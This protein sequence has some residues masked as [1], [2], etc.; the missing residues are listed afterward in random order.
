MRISISKGR[1]SET[2]FS[3]CTFFIADVNSESTIRTNIEYFWKQY[4][5]DLDPIVE[6]LVILAMG[7]FSVDKRIPRSGLINDYQGDNWTRQIELQIPVLELNKWEG[8]KL[9]LSKCI[10]FL[11]GDE[12]NINFYQ[13]DIRFRPSKKRDIKKAKALPEYDSVSLFSGGLDSF[14]GAIYYLDKG[15]R[16]LFIGC[17]EYVALEARIDEVFSAIA[18]EF[19]YENDKVNVFYVNPKIPQGIDQEVRNRFRENTSRTRSFLFLTAAIVMAS[20]RGGE[21]P[22][23]V[24]ENGFIGINVPLTP[25]RLGSC[26]TRTT[27]VKFLSDFNKILEKVGIHNQ[28][29]NP[30][31]CMSKGQI[32]ALIREHPSF[33]LTVGKTISCSHPMQ[34]RMQKAPVP[35]NCGYCYPCIIRKASLFCNGIIDEYVDSYNHNLS[36]SSDFLMNPKYSN[37]D[38]GMNR[39]FRAVLYSLKTFEL[40]D[41]TKLKGRLIALCGLQGQEVDDFANMY[42]KSM[43]E[44]KIYIQHLC[45]T[46]KKLAEYLGWEIDEYVD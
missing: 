6:D 1:I 3:E 29:I 11:S 26:S 31:R 42:V 40:M 27:H 33:K 46:D 39:D 19:Q 41:E 5:L 24:P 17:R 22:V 9:E 15:L 36:L 30:F 4:G 7:I 28:I 8:V 44:M 38:T 18:D 45:K 20:L 23:I 43:N 35:I 10:S 25:S 32:V 14:A 16:P 37:C 13:T 2:L 12:W 34:G 21:I